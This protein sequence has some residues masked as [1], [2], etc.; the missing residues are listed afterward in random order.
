MWQTD[1]TIRKFYATENGEVHELNQ[2]SSVIARELP[3]SPATED[4]MSGSSGEAG[5]SDPGCN[6]LYLHLTEKRH[7]HDN[8]DD[9]VGPSRSEMTEHNMAYW[10]LKGIKSYR[11]SWSISSEALAEN[12][13]KQVE[14]RA[15]SEKRSGQEASGLSPNSTGLSWSTARFGCSHSAQNRERLDPL[16]SIRSQDPLES[17]RDTGFSQDSADRDRSEI[18]F[19]S[20]DGEE[21]NK[22]V[23]IIEQS[24]VLMAP[25]AQASKYDRH[26][27]NSFAR[28][29]SPA[30]LKAAPP[31]E[32]HI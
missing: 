17:E 14:S 21:T 22:T 30:V 7:I 19:G 10:F 8:Q 4:P 6:Q 11:P 32:H 20:T 5:T 13:C 26:L 12:Q 16:R 24:K 9:Y 1:A 2:H 28:S 23:E 31:L 3:C 29:C 25:R 18:D 27:K 15:H